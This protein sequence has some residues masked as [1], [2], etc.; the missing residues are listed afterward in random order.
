MIAAFPLASVATEPR[1][2]EPAVNVTV[3]V[4]VLWPGPET[5]AEKVKLSPAVI[6]LDETERAV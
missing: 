5:E 6:V 3:P 1:L 2:R 4:G